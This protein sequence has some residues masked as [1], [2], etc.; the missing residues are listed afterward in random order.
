MNLPVDLPP[1]FVS[2]IPRVS[3]DEPYCNAIGRHN[4][5]YSPR[6]RG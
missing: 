5:M 6:E 4:Y 1:A 2:G 3:G